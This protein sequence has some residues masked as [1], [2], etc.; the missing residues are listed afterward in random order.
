M[1][2]PPGAERRSLDHQ[3][4]LDA[5]D[6]V[7]DHEGSASRGKNE[8]SGCS[9]VVLGKT[10]AHQKHGCE[11]QQAL[12]AAHPEKRE[13]QDQKNDCRSRGEKPYPHAGVVYDGIDVEETEVKNGIHRPAVFAVLGQES[14]RIRA[15]CER[16]AAA[17]AG[18]GIPGTSPPLSSIIG[19]PLRVIKAKS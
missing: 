5:V 15:C 4:D 7:V 12:P 17:A 16:I 8:E 10:D 1:E 6:L 14:H 19:G 9:A 2:P 18:W 11:M 13:I 3:Q